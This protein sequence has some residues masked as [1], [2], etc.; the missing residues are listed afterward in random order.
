MFTLHFP[1]L[2]LVNWF[3]SLRTRRKEST[4]HILNTVDLQIPADLYLGF[5]SSGTIE[6][7][8]LYQQKITTRTSF[9]RNQFSIPLPLV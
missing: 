4:F 7:T 5:V 1:K 3:Y 6:T 2:Y 8:I 9:V